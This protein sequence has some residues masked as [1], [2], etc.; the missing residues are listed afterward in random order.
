MF[1]MHRLV[2]YNH[3]HIAMYSGVGGSGAEQCRFGGELYIVIFYSCCIKNNVSIMLEE[4]FNHSDQ[5]F[6]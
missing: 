6:K 2:T 5:N 1:S 3:N 4:D